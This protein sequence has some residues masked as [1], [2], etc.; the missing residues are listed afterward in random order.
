VARNL[1]PLAHDHKIL[2]YAELIERVRLGW[3]HP[4]LRAKFRNETEGHCT[5]GQCR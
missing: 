2:H 4:K 3:N 5:S 1:K